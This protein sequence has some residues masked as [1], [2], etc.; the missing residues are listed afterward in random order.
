MKFTPLYILSLL[1]FI[2]CNSSNNSPTEEEAHKHTQADSKAIP[3]AAEA[4][5]DVIAG[6]MQFKEYGPKKAPSLETALRDSL[7]RLFDGLH[8]Q[9]MS[10]ETNDSLKATAKAYNKVIR[11]HIAAKY[12]KS[13]EQCLALRMN[14]DMHDF[15]FSTFGYEA[16]SDKYMLRSGM[17]FLNESG[18]EIRKAHKLFLKINASG[19]K[20]A[21]QLDTPNKLF[22]RLAAFK[23]DGET[24]AAAQKRLKLVQKE[25]ESLGVAA[26]RIFLKPIQPAWEADCSQC[27]FNIK[28]YAQ[29]VELTYED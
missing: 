6:I 12:G 14:M 24:D 11:A 26:D 20:K 27:P 18:T 8:Y 22:I 29:R 16:V 5:K 23:A 4:E 21:D 13:W 2:A 9:R 19:L 3:P 7:L 25:L 1:L 10:T 15:L 17:I 28:G